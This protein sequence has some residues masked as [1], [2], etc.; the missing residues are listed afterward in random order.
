MNLEHNTTGSVPEASAAEQSPA[1]SA[2]A[3]PSPQPQ[4]NSGG[5][6]GKKP[7]VI[8]IMIL[9][10]AAFLLMA[11]SLL[12]HQRSNTEALG[13]LQNSVN[14]MQAVQETQDKIIGLQEELSQARE[15][16][17]SLQE[18]LDASQEKILDSQ[19]QADALLGLYSLQQAYLSGDYDACSEI[20]QSMEDQGLPPLL[21]DE[22][23]ISGTTAPAERYQQLKEAVLN[24]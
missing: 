16:Q 15:E 21:S 3:V 10:L 18:Q 24:P 2:P 12:M 20:L 8:Y 11:L 7:V 17:E 4:P 6:S 13:Q 5:Q 23:G 9:F 14:A 19:K 22:P 1:Q